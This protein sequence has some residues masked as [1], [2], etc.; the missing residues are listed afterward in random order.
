MHTRSHSHIHSHAHSSLRAAH[1]RSGGFTFIELILVVVIA[2]ILATG[3]FSSIVNLQR[4]ARVNDAYKSVVS[5]ADL[6]R[7]FALSG[8]EVAGGDAKSGK[9]VLA[10]PARYGLSMKKET[11][12]G[13]K[14]ATFRLCFDPVGSMPG[15]M[16]SCNLNVMELFRVDLSRVDVRIAAGTGIGAGETILVDTSSNKGFALFYRAPFGTFTVDAD[17]TI[18]DPTMWYRF[19][20]C[21]GTCASGSGA[22]GGTPTSYTKSVT[23][24][25]NVGV[26]EIA[27]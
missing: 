9:T 7:H 26:P 3:A 13:K 14:M 6:A 20:F 22:G 16:N 12:D 27:N 4:T 18:P 17:M 23:F 5:F 21:E 15:G 11:V 25:S 24:F 19:D 10:I 2:A 8:R 1:A